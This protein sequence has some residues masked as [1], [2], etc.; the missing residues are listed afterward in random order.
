[1]NKLLAV[2]LLSVLLTA[3]K[4]ESNPGIIDNA[5]WHYQEFEDIGLRDISIVSRDVAFLHGT[6]LDTTPFPQYICQIFKTT[7]K[8]ESWVQVPTKEKVNEVGGYR[9]FMITETTGFLAGYYE[10][11]RT[12]DG[13]INWEQHS[14]IDITNSF[15]RIIRVND[16]TLLGYSGRGDPY[17]SYDLGNTW[18]SFLNKLEVNPGA[19]DF[20]DD[21]IGYAAG[22]DKIYKTND[23]GQTW[24]SPGDFNYSCIDLEFFDS[25]N[26]IALSMQSGPYASDEC[27]FHMTGDGGIT[28]DVIDISKIMGVG[29]F[30]LLLKY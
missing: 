25:N 24:S 12:N 17:I 30:T 14:E 15:S 5:E 2:V 18:S 28:W 7:D 19:V 6:T 4:K 27:L 9:L 3:C 21:N 11:L 1:M 20:V 22:N 8:G 26:G 10:L 13:G 29:A 23:G 16:T